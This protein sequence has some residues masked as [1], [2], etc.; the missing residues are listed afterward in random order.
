MRD[1]QWVRVDDVADDSENT[2]T[3]EEYGGSLFSASFSL[4]S[5]ALA[6]FLLTFVNLTY[7][8]EHIYVI[9]LYILL[10]CSVKYAQILYIYIPNQ[11]L[12][13]ESEDL[14]L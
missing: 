8:Y 11:K 6:I 2:W 9:Y 13:F 7:T 5:L 14:I 10:L 3:E 1:Q 4:M 12:L